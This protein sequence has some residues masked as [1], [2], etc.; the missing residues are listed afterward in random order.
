M[1]TTPAWLPALIL[2]SDHGGDWQR[3][4]DAVYAVFNTDFIARRAHYEAKKILLIGRDAELIDGKERR[5]WHCVSEGELEDAR[6]PDLR[7]CERMP[8][9]RPVIEHASEPTVDA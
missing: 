8:W 6:S 1:S 4:I 9:M 3:Y 7:R 2:L 5:F